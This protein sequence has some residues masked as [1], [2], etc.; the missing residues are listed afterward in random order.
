MV[1]VGRTS[2][3][4]TQ[5]GLVGQSWN[6]VSFLTLTKRAV[7]RAVTCA[8]QE[9]QVDEALKSHSALPMDMACAIAD[10]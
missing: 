3:A 7:R 1:P 4:S 9:G 5:H 2:S 6:P 10:A 8:C